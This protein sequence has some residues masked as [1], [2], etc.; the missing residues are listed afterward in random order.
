MAGTGRI[1][2]CANFGIELL[3]AVMGRN[4]ANKANWE[5]SKALAPHA[6]AVLGKGTPDQLSAKLAL[7]IGAYYQEVARSPRPSASLSAPWP[8]RKR[9][10]GPQH[11]GH[12]ICLNELA[13]VL[14]SRGDLAAS[15]GLVE[16]ALAMQKVLGPEHPDVARSLITLANL[17]RNQWDLAAAEPLFDRALA[18]WKKISHP[19]VQNIKEFANLL[20][21]SVRRQG[22]CMSRH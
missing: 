5:T 22:R 9:C 11:P 17:R 19:T 4:V 15:R 13:V 21:A 1:T 3:V 14:G 10:S 7:K 20:S 8:T 12:S 18:I 16:R 2:D 6:L